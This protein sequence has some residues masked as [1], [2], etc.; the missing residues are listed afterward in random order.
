MAASNYNGYPI[1]RA[2]APLLIIAVP[3][4][5]MIAWVLYQQKAQLN[6]PPPQVAV[7][8]VSFG[9]EN[10]A[11]FRGNSELTGQ[12][13][14]NLPDELELAWKFQTG[15]SIK[16]TPVIAGATAYVSST[17]KYLYA[18]DLQT[19]K[20]KWRFEADDELEASPLFHDGVIY[21]G[22]NGGLL[23]AID[24][25]TGQPK[26]T[27]KDAGKI[28]GSANIAID[29]E[30]GRPL[31][32]FGSYD[33]NLYCLNADDGS[34][35]FIHPADNYINGSVAVANN[36]VF[37]GSCD[38]MIYQVPIADPDA[39]KTIDAGSY[40][41]A[42]PAVHN[43][44]IYA[45]NYDGMFIA[46]DIATQTILWKYDDTQDAFFSSPAVNEEVV[47]VGCRD[48]KLYCFDKT[49]GDIRWTF[50]AGDNFDSSPVICGGK[51]IIGNDDGRLYILDI[52]TGKEV[53]SYT[54]GSPITGSAA[55]AQNHILI[56]DDNGTLYAF[57]AE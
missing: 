35:R 42:N 52:Q 31:L 10:W 17:D 40:V 1:S 47:I 50:L 15:N 12:A 48:K 4:A 57:T 29:P 46:A 20:E 33:S 43:G 34:I 38:A 14:G 6:T 7:Q 28:T 9:G 25:A 55:I 54:L 56:G 30:T 18:I 24:A 36:T 26:W 11:V 19:G 8:D 3:V 44:I 2:V 45:G 13:A 39:V 32:V 27:F 22:S 51:V 53:F 5:A 41:A 16:S 21:I 23:Y 49:T 37:F